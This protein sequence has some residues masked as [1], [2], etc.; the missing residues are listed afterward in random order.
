MQLA[1]SSHEVDCDQPLRGIVNTI[2]KLPNAQKL[3]A[4]I[5]REGTIRI[6]IRNTGL[7][8]QFGAFWDRQERV[9]GVH[10]LRDRMGDHTPR[11]GKP[12][13]RSSL[14]CRMP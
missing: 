9:I 13:A 1:W 10:F 6:A 4:T 12:S 3:I 2:L 8:N 7:S 14:S 11:K 5:Q